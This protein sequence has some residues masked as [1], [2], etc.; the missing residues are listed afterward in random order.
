M[1]CIQITTILRLTGILSFGVYSNSHPKDGLLDKVTYSSH[2]KNIPKDAVRVHPIMEYH[3]LTQ[4][5]CNNGS[6]NM[7][8]SNMN[9][10]TIP[11]SLV[12]IFYP[13]GCST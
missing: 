4:L 6:R 5:S 3:R 9:K 10:Q 12:E 11:S 13:V 7:T 1:Q 8:K 2:K